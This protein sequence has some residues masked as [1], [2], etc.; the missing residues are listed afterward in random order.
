MVDH[1]NPERA[2]H[3]VFHTGESPAISQ[4]F[5]HFTPPRKIPPLNFYSPTP[6]PTKQQFASYNPIKQHF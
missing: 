4:K 3:R 2:Y 1:V 6:P 5:A